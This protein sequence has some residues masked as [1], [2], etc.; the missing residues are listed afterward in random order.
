MMKLDMV[1]FT[2]TQFRPYVQQHSVDYERQK[3]KSL[4]EI[5]RGASLVITSRFPSSQKESATSVIQDFEQTT[6]GSIGLLAQANT[7]CCGDLLPVSL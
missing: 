3:F 5:Q 1:N 6:M 7:V 2:I 4:L